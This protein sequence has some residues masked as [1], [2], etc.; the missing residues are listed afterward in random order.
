MNMEATDPTTATYAAITKAF[1]HFNLTLFENRL[2]DPLFVFQRGRSFKGYFWAGIWNEKGGCEKADEIALN[3]DLLSTRSIEETL[4]TLVHEMTHLEQQHFGKPS[5]SGYHN[6]EWAGLMERVGLIP[7]ETGQPGG[8]KTG[9]RVTHYIDEA[10]AFAAEVALLIENGFTIPWEAIDTRS[11]KAEKRK[12]AKA[13]S[14]SKF[15]C[16]SCGQVARAKADAKLICGECVVAME[17]A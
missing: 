4:S 1:R 15:E 17:L 7:S 12:K 6:K 16:P 3:P 11:E 14:K 13:A 10:G 5:R 2:P 9:Q 8:K